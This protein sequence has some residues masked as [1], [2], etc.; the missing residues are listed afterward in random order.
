M[1]TKSLTTKI[2]GHAV[3]IATLAFAAIPAAQAQSLPST[4]V[5]AVTTYE[6]VG[7]YWS[8]PGASSATGCNVSYRKVG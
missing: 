8:A 6:S 7:I 5:S 1:R 2:R 4:G 3:A